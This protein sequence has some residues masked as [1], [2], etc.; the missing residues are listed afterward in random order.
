MTSTPIENNEPSQVA[1]NAKGN[2][3]TKSN[4]PTPPKPVSRDPRLKRP[5]NS[6]RTGSANTS[7]GRARSSLNAVKHGGYVTAK[8]ADLAYHQIL[9]ELTQRINPVGAVEEGV[10]ESIAIDLFRPSMLGKLEVERYSLRS[11][12]TT[13]TQSPHTVTSWT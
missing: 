9:G 3:Q 1:Q 2:P 5:L 11:T 6:R 8:T 7:E 10:V 12:Q 4:R 13:C